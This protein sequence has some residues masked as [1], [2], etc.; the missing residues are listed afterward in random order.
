MY[1][2]LS[3]LRILVVGALFF[4]SF[5]GAMERAEKRKERDENDEAALIRVGAFDIY[6][7]YEQNQSVEDKL[8][9]AIRLSDVPNFKYLF[10]EKKVRLDTQHMEDAFLYINNAEILHVL[11]KS[12]Y[13]GPRNALH[14]AMDSCKKSELIP[15]Y[16]SFGYSPLALDCDF[17]PLWAD[18]AGM[19]LAP[20]T[21][22]TPLIT[23]AW[24]ARNHEA[25]DEVINKFNALTR[26][27]SPLELQRL[28]CYRKGYVLNCLDLSEQSIA[29]KAELIKRAKELEAMK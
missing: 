15:V 5:C 13:W 17:V 29:L 22:E 19:A 6:E 18:C 28:I 26:G 11:L 24:Q 2:I 20:K 25:S 27:L 23:L 16:R 14:F 12:G 9:E 1:A 3:V 4:S 8:L 10:E 7:D 21:P